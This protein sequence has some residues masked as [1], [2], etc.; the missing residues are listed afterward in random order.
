VT[1]RCK[2]RRTCRQCGRRV[3]Y[4]FGHPRLPGLPGTHCRGCARRAGWPVKYAREGRGCDALRFCGL[5][6]NP[7]TIYLHA[8]EHGAVFLCRQDGDALVVV[9]VMDATLAQPV[10][11]PRW[12]YR[13]NHLPRKE[14]A[15]GR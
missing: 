2:A 5:S 14:D 6:R 10:T 9:S 13:G 12:A 3:L 4:L 15:D 11:L 8:K 7:G 1:T